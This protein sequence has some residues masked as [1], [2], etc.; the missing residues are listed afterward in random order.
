MPKQPKNRISNDA[1]LRNMYSVRYFM[2]RI[3]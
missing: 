3:T 2:A 1:N